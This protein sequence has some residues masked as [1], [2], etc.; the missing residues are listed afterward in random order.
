MSHV[1]VD[2]V[3]ANVTRARLQL[4]HQDSPEA[5]WNLE[6]LTDGTIHRLL[7][8]GTVAMPAL[9]VL[10]VAFVD[11]PVELAVG[12][13]PGC[14]T[15]SPTGTK[16]NVRVEGRSAQITG[17]TALIW[18]SFVEGRSRPYLIDIEA[19]TEIGPI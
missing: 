5:D 9:E 15:S 17:Q 11:D 12:G 13:Q 4:Y 18:S 16:L 19:D 7:M 1:I 6:L 3:R 10:E 2:G 14:L 8:S